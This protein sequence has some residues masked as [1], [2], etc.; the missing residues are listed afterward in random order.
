VEE[1]QE[2]VDYM[3]DAME[4]YTTLSEEKEEEIA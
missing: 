1:Y 2:L 4:Q 3:L